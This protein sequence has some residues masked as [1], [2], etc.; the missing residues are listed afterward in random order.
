MI[1]TMVLYYIDPQ[2]YI[3][4]EV[5]DS[6]L[7]AN[8]KDC[9]IVYY[10]S[11]LLERD[12]VPGVDYR[13]QFYYS[14]KTGLARVTSYIRSIFGIMSDVWKER[15]EVVHIQWF[16]FWYVDYL[17]LIFL[18]LLRIQIVYTAHNVMP[19]N[20][21]F[22]DR[23][24]HRLYYQKVDAII[25]HT[26]QTQRE[27]A[28]MFHVNPKKIRVIRHGLL[29]SV[30]DQRAVTQRAAYFRRR[31]DI[32]RDCIVF[33]SMGYQNYYKGADIIVDTWLST[34]ELRYNPDIKLLVVGEVESADLSQLS[35]C[36]NVVVINKMVP[37]V[38]FEAYIQLVSVMLL[39]YRSISQSGV[40]LTALQRKVPV[41]VSATGGLT[42]PLLIAK[43]G[44]CMGDATVENLQ[45]LLTNLVSSPEQI[46]E[47]RNNHKAFEE[48]C[49][50]YSWDVIG[51]QTRALYQSLRKKR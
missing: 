17:L 30:E 27:L 7:L 3:N 42:E 4:L 49:N 33:A 31:L 32:S 48:V 50:A 19:H 39:P 22:G 35:T 1:P 20:P 6:S 24:K 38:D 25:V 12:D 37:N 14:E 15:P 40:L 46:E 11:V 29:P 26:A 10:H 36:S 23:I 28:K 34:P 51:Q 43:V 2:S 45:N 5:Y 16:K 18:K 13:E 44:W 21:R 9:R 8:I 47:V 41:L